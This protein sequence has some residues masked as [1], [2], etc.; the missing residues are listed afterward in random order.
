[1]LVCVSSGKYFHYGTLINQEDVTMK[2]MLWMVLAILLLCAG[3]GGQA[4]TALPE[5]GFENSGNSYLEWFVVTPEQLIA[6]INPKL[7]EAG[8]SELVSVRDDGEWVEFNDT[9]AAQL[10][11]PIELTVH[12]DDRNIRILESQFDIK[13][14]DTAKKAGFYFS[15][16]ISMFSPRDADKIM[17]ALHVF[18]EFNEGVA[19]YE[20]EAGN[21]I[22]SFAGRA[23][24]IRP[25]EYDETIAPIAP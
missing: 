3:C 13:D 25:I 21:V 6:D 4:N 5:N 11:N 18:D 14:E 23:L 2:R 24:S 15:M 10:Y 12:K 19:F 9:G 16:L 8:Y 17:D 1:M 20:Y 22:Y 7:V